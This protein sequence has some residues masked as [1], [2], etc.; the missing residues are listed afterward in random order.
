MHEDAHMIGGKLHA[1]RD[2]FR[3]E[4]FDAFLTIPGAT[5]YKVEERHANITGK[6]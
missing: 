1:F 6:C 2:F 5:A 3:R 4:F